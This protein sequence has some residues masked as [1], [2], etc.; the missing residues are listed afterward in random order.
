MVNLMLIEY[1]HQLFACKSRENFIT[2][3]KH[4]PQGSLLEM[5]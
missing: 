2:R 4:G 3:K 5:R 1:D